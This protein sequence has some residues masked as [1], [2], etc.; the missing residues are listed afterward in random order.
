MKATPY[1][2]AGKSKADEVELMFNNIAPKY[3]L[4]NNLLSVGIDKI[5]RKKVSR[6]LPS[7]TKT[8]L[9][10]ATGTGELAI[11]ISKNKSINIT[12][13]D[14]SQGMLDIG[15]L[16]L[17]NQNL[18]KQINLI[19]A[20]S[21]KFYKWL[22]KDAVVCLSRKLNNF[23]VLYGNIENSKLGELQEFEGESAAKLKE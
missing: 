15:I 7:N 20:D 12:G 11:E 21:E 18:T 4:L 16:K 23:V 2:I 3:D 9:D 19:K 5:W 17:K 1:N 13:I 22:Y 8:V 10:V 14:I 6:L